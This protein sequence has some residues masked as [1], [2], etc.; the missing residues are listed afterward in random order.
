MPLDRPWR[1]RQCRFPGRAAPVNNSLAVSALLNL[2]PGKS[3][4]LFTNSPECSKA[5]AIQRTYGSMASM[6]RLAAIQA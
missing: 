5:Q 1:E 4:G 3:A 6:Y 2:L